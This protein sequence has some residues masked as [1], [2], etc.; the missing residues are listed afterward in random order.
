[1]RR[2]CRHD[3]APALH[4]RRHAA[5]RHACRHATRAD[6]AE[7]RLQYAAADSSFSS[8]M[9]ACRLEFRRHR[10][11]YCRQSERHGCH[12][13]RWGNDHATKA[14]MPRRRK[15]HRAA[16]TRL[17][18][19]LPRAARFPPPIS[20]FHI[21][22]FSDAATDAS[23][24]YQPRRQRAT[25]CRHARPALAAFN[26]AE[27]TPRALCFSRATD[28]VCSPLP[29]TAAHRCRR[30]AFNESPSRLRA[31][32][33]RHFADS[34]HWISRGHRRHHS[35]GLRCRRRDAAQPRR[36]RRLA[37]MPAAAAHAVFEMSARD[38]DF[39]APRA[40]APHEEKM[41]T[42]FAKQQRTPSNAP[43]CRKRHRRRRPSKWPES[44]RGRP[45]T[46]RATIGATRHTRCRE[47]P[48]FAD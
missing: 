35:R 38:A 1:M 12:A 30:T 29:R 22:R 36:C 46:R 2:R 14:A 18:P 32:H 10:H 4:C 31:D 17:P 7:R 8:A 3:A 21:F 33:F 47:R 37:A 39:R 23:A 45:A 40:A 5:E 28:A 42:K 34:C 16:A 48:I 26:T 43:V 27:L 15:L 9:P 25:G 19:R 6:A 41:R 20:P 44:S 24:D 11:R 13:G